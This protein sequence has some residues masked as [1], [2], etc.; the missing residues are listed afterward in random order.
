MEETKKPK[1]KK[2]AEPHGHGHQCGGCGGCGNKGGGHAKPQE[3]L[4]WESIAK[5]KAAELENYIKR[6]KDSVS[7]AF[8]DGRRHA[9]L[10]ILPIGDTLAEAART[11]KNP[12][13]KKGIEMLA[14]KFDATLAGLGLE[15]IAVKKGDKFDPHIHSSI[16]QSETGD[17]SVT[18]V[19][20]K[21]YKFAGRVIRPAMVKI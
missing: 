11:V 5:Y 2:D 20:Q 19:L 10:S 1:A 8:D 17:P 18:E 6:T 4:D 7:A 21:G 3:P 16:N 12:D 9:I 15:E 13:D 14:K